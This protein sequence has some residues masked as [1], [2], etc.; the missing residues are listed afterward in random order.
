MVGNFHEKA[1]DVNAGN[2]RS[3]KHWLIAD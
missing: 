1:A 3:S 2:G